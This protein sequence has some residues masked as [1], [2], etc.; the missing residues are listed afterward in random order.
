MS[1]VNKDKLN[2]DKILQD[3]MKPDLIVLEVSQDEM[4]A[5]LHL[6][7]PGSNEEWPTYEEVMA[8][9]NEYGIVFGLKDLVVKRVV[10]EKITSPVLIAEGQD[11][12]RGEDA[13]IKYLFETNR[14]KLIPKELENGRVDHRE[15][16]LIHNV[17]KGDKLV[18]RRPPTPGIPG[19]TVT[20]KELKARPGKDM[21]VIAGKN[22]AWN[23][24]KTI[25][26]ATID[27][28]PSLV[29]RKVSVQD[30]H[31]VAGNV[32]YGTGN[33][34]FTGSVQVR[35]DVENGFTVKAAGDIFIYGNV[36][37]GFLYA[38]GNITVNGGII[39]QDKTIVQC[40]GDLYARHI[41]RSK[42]DVLG[43]IQV[44]DTII[45]SHVNSGGKISLGTQK[46]LIMG[47]VV[48]AK[49]E[50]SAQVLGSRMGTITEVEVGTDP[51]SRL[52]LNDIEKRLAELEKEMD[53]V[54]KALVILNKQGFNLPPEKAEMKARITRTSFVMKGEK[55]KLEA[56]RDEILEEM[57]QRSVD[58][59]RIK[60][61]RIIFPGVRV[62]I[63]KAVRIFQ[64][65]VRY[66]I[67]TYHEGE[68][69]VQ[70]Y[71]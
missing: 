44:R 63:G 41:E 35:G 53:K 71:R 12:V 27:G 33:I 62:I 61:Q 8:K 9:I 2:P 15:L 57:T 14:M 54:E 5:Y 31:R 43:N 70:S 60:V 39:G 7:K 22:A 30:L 6:E 32:G 17:K 69:V 4:K 51:A 48:R 19:Q 1:E 37:G 23:E 68:V 49:E 18:E 3:I 45:H 64:D 13:Q 50:I 58:R 36:D 52:E 16:S 46:G 65:E 21:Q 11:P 10:E 59:G 66:S 42:V 56:R 24:E 55:R 67:L 25:L 47:G 34:D 38:D 29:G 28:E 26:T 40:K 20:G